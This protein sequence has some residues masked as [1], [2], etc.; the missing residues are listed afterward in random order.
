MEVNQVGYK[1]L[2]IKLQKLYATYDALRQ[3]NDIY[4][5]TKHECDIVCDEIDRILKSEEY[6]MKKYFKY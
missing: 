6:M 5:P 2:I 1:G 4:E 3:R